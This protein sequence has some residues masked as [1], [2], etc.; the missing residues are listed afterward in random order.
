MEDAIEWVR[1]GKCIVYPTS[2]LP[3]LG[4][5]P[6]VGALDALFE[7]KGRPRS[8]P[9][10]LGVANLSQAS[11]IVEVTDDV[12]EIL[13][14]FPKG[15][16]TIVLKPKDELDIRLGSKGVAVRVVSDPRAREL[17]L[18]TG[19]LTATS[20][21]KTGEDPLLDC[22]AAADSLCTSEHDVLGV[23]GECDGGLPSTLI[24][25]HTVCD[26]P[27]SQSIEVV[28]EGKVSTEEV[29]AWWKRRT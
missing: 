19:P 17:L 24:A 22:I 5:I 28:R 16:L 21:N 18:K 1:S 23:D 14:D 13:E 8:A 29:L 3:A 9:V 26:S 27:E 15:S 7:I 12:Y 11:E 2:T 10:S 20:A 6:E 4:C 25:W